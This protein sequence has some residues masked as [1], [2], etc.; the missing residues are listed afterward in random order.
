M[1]PKGVNMR[2]SQSLQAEFSGGRQKDWIIYN[3][4]LFRL[5]CIAIW[6]H[7]ST[8]PWLLGEYVHMEKNVLPV[9]EK[10]YMTMLE[11]ARFRQSYQYQIA[12]FRFNWKDQVQNNPYWQGLI[13]NLSD[14]PDK[15]APDAKI[16]LSEFLAEMRSLVLPQDVVWGN[17]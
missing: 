12:R 16:D 6:K 2:P 9:L 10:G 15:Q 11:A 7:T 1:K 4:D 5:F 13:K 17:I 3:P 8:S 14:D